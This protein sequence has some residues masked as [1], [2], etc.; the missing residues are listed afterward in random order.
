MKNT[1][2]IGIV[3]DFNSKSKS[4]NETNQALIHSASALNKEEIVEWIPTESI[5][6]DVARKLAR[7]QAILCSPGS[8]Y[9]SME[10]ALRAIT[11]AR[12][13]GVPFLGT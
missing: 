5:T 2:K 13:E 6:G 10:G 1:V 11:Y 8:P 4:H 12:T 9:Q 3:G 7:F